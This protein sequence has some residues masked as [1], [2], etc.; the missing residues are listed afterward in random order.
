MNKA[1]KEV[2]EE[3]GLWDRDGKSKYM[4]DMGVII[5]K[6]ND[7]NM[8]VIKSVMCHGPRFKDVTQ[9]QYMVFY[10]K[11]WFQ[12]CYQVCHDEYLERLMEAYRR[13][14]DGTRIEKLEKKVDYY[15]S[16]LK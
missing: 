16:K 14:E 10:R 6:D 13:K 12:G 7:S 15:K 3:Y 2:K 4:I 1:W 5:E 11:G 8:I 9:D